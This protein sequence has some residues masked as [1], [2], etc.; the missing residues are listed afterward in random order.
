MPKFNIKESFE[1][2]AAP[3]FQVINTGKNTVTIKGVAVRK[4]QISRN[5]RRY[6]DEE[7]KMAARTWIGKPVTINHA[8]WDR[9][10]PMY[11]GRKVPGNVRW[12]EYNK[13]A[14]EYQIDIKKQPYVDLIRNKSVDV[15]GV[16]IEADYIYNRC[17]RCGKNFYTQEEF[18][19][20]M[21]NEEFIRNFEYEPHQILGRAVSLVLSPE[22]PGVQGTTIE[23]MEKYQRPKFKGFSQLLET[24]TT[25]EKK[26]ETYMKKLEGKAVL[27]PQGRKTVKQL[28]EQAE[29]G[30]KPPAHPTEKPEGGCDPG[31]HKD[32][33]TGECVAD[34]IEAEPEKVIEQE[35]GTCPPGF[36]DDG[37]GGCAADPIPEEQGPAN[38]PQITP[39]PVIEIPKVDVTVPAPTEQPPLDVTQTLGEQEDNVQPVPHPV[40]AGGKECPIAGTHWDELAGTCV[41]DVITEDPTGAVEPPATKVIVELKLPKLLRFGEFGGTPYTSMD[42][43]KSKNSDKDDPAAYCAEIMRQSHGETLKE[44]SGD[45]YKRMERNEVAEYIRDVKIAESVNKDTKAIAQIANVIKTLP[46]N[47]QK[48]LLMESKL[49]ASYDANQTRQFNEALK[50]VAN[51]INSLNKQG[52]SNLEKSNKDIVEQVN[53]QLKGLSESV[54]KLST[55]TNTRLG[56]LATANAKQARKVAEQKKDYEKILEATDKVSMNKIRSLEQRVKEQD[57]ELEKRKCGENEHYDE[58]KGECV[59]NTPKEPEQTEESKKLTETVSSLTTK[60]ENLEAKLTG[61]F[62]GNQKPLDEKTQKTAVVENPMG[63]TKSK[64]RKKNA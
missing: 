28:K 24:V 29:D 32:P 60:F 3:D 57:D 36:H 59:P 37:A 19:N 18:E 1:W 61:Q 30:V 46:R 20:H 27:T 43:C 51:A 23:L 2:M 4:G 39:E 54:N 35:E 40:E 10:H 56:Q 11:D 50:K 5:R 41:P 63:A 64:G 44:M 58:E 62:K 42:D 34:E 25:Y 22:Q 33:E 47:I 16:S 6:V 49:R 21:I 26:K 48:Q 12:M 8:P 17:S 52:I 38:A 14:M 55:F 45:I 9:S 31:F 13:G 53:K 15:K 7:L